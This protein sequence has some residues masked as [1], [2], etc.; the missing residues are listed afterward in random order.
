[1]RHEH[2]EKSLLTQELY[3]AR[4]KVR[5]LEDVQMEGIHATHILEKFKQTICDLLDPMDC[6]MWKW[7]VGSDEATLIVKR[8]DDL[9]TDT[10]KPGLTKLTLPEIERMIHPEDLQS[11][12]E[13]LIAHLE[14]KTVDALEVDFRVRGKSGD[15]RWVRLETEAI[16]R[17]HE[18]RPVQ[19]VGCFADVNEVCTILERFVVGAGSG[20]VAKP[21]IRIKVAAERPS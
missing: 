5:A 13:D 18:G 19:A 9:G 12:K 16:Q 11:V 6:G 3:E 14:S 15:W 17:N 8:W 10:I 20:A 21:Q 2:G 4:P 7:T 1:M